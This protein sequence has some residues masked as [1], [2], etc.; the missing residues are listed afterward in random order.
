VTQL[1]YQAAPVDRRSCER[2]FYAVILKLLI[3]YFVVSII[4]LPF[5]DRLWL[6]ELP[7]LALI[8]LPKTSFAIWL[9][10]DVVIPLMK[11]VGLSRGSPSPDMIRASPYALALAYLIPLTVV[12][13]VVVWRWRAAS[14]RRW[15]LLIM[16]GLAA[17]DFA[18]TLIFACRPGLT[19]Y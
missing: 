5:I 4:T 8:Q 11:T 17:L 7:L 10:S 19:I 16:F 12:V 14:P 9:R 2:R 15:L 3:G 13:T 18:F 1:D 6:G